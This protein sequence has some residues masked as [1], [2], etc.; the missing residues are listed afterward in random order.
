M[1]KDEYIAEL[2]YKDLCI[3]C[4]EQD[5]QQY[6]QMLKMYEEELRSRMPTNEFKAFATKVAKT[7]FLAEVMASPN[8]GFRDTVLENWEDI[9]KEGD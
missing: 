7:T 4:L 9:T 5:K 6:L 1:T 3:K 8:E 2:E